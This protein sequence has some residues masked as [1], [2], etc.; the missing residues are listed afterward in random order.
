M[1]QA[2]SGIERGALN[3]WQLGYTRA[4]GPQQLM[5]SGK[6]QMRLG[7]H[8]SGGEHRNAPLP[9]SPRGGRQQPR[10]ADTRLA[11][12]HERLAAR[13]DFIQDRPQETLFLVATH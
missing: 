10:L 5:Q 3:G 1:R 2:E 12:K 11:A 7:L 8:A 13:R 6:R 4:H 9:R